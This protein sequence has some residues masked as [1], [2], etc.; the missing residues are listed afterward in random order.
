MAVGVE[1]LDGGGTAERFCTVFTD[2]PWRMSSD[3]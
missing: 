3:A 1:G 2:S